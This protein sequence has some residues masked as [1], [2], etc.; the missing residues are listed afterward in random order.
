MNLTYSRS[1]YDVIIIGSGISSL[2]SA[3]ILSRSGKKVLVL[4]KHYK[5]G[6]YLHCFNR[7]NKRF[8][9]G[10]HYVGGMEPGQPFHTLLSYL[11]VYEQ[12]DFIKLDECF[13]EMIF[14]EF[15]CG[16]Y[17]GYKKNID[18]LVKIFPNEE[19]AITKYFL[20]I[21]ET[22]NLFPTYV[23]ERNCPQSE[24]LRA[25]SISLSE[26][27]ESLT[28]N[29]K[30]RKV[31]YSYCCLHGV[32]PQDVSIGIH[33]LVTDSL[34]QSAYGFSDGGDKLVNRFV[35][36]IKDLGGEFRN[37]SE[38]QKINIEDKKVK[39]IEV[40]NEILTADYYISGIHPKLTFDL[41]GRDILRPAFRS[42]LEKVEETQSMFGV[43]II[44]DKKPAIEPLK[45]YYLF[46]SNESN[47]FASSSLSPR[48][49]DPND[50]ENTDFD[51]DTIFINSPSRNNQDE[52]NHNYPIAIHFSSPIKWFEKWNKSQFGG[53]PKEYDK[54][55]KYLSDKAIDLVEQKIPGFKNCIKS[56]TA[57]SP[58]TYIHYNGSIYGSPYGIYHSI[59]NTGFKAIGPKTHYKNLFLTGQSTLTPGILGSAISGIRSLDNMIK[60]DTILADLNTIKKT[61]L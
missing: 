25:M 8:D 20:K 54:F 34:L 31:F 57:S 22:V 18:E 61:N 16:F 39:N 10:G 55:K 40:N 2:T 47:S 30:L 27:V 33:S 29:E 44:C 7:G 37:K 49:S 15:R 41:I 51:I 4:E 35:Q 58:L 38:V 28:D 60:L 32:S 52:K 53:R 46:Y 48:D 26:F 9:V 21:K 42:R 36:K 43:Q 5:L 13:D 14:P 59:K 6:G 19:Q 1:H 56:Y 45:N 12:K 50:K 23:F 11:G 24:T 3:L 17:Q